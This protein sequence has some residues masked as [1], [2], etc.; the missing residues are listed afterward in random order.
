MVLIDKQTGQKLYPVCNFKDNQHRLAW[1]IDVCEHELIEAL[2]DGSGPER[3][4]YLD[5]KL[6]ELREIL[7]LFNGGVREKDG[8]VYLT[9]QDGRKAKNVIN[10]YLATHKY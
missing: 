7:E 10:R 4:E 3:F 9:Y 5:N 8:L 6:N 2:T 1:A